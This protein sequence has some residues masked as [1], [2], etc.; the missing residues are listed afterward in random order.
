MRLK[1]VPLGDD[2]PCVA[3]AQRFHADQAREQLTQARYGWF[4]YSREFA[5]EFLHAPLWPWLM[6]GG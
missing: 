2:R 3:C 1:Q 4:V 6:H 5:W